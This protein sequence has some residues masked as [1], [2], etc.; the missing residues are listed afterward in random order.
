MVVG[1]GGIFISTLF[2]YPFPYVGLTITV[3]V[4]SVLNLATTK[5]Q[6]YLP[7]DFKTN[8]ELCRKATVC[9]VYGFFFAGSYYT[10][11]IFNIIFA[12]LHDYVV[13][14]VI[15]TFIYPFLCAGIRMVAE[16]LTMLMCPD[17]MLETQFVFELWPAIYHQFQFATSPNTLVN[18]SLLIS[19]FLEQTVE[20]IKFTRSWRRLRKTVRKKLLSDLFNKNEQKDETCGQDASIS[21]SEVRSGIKHAALERIRTTATL[22]DSVD[23]AVHPDSSSNILPPRTDTIITKA[24]KAVVQVSFEKSIKTENA[25]QGDP[26]GPEAGG[27]PLPL[28]KTKDGFI[29]RDTL[30][31]IALSNASKEEHKKEECCMDTAGQQDKEKDNRLN[32]SLH[33]SHT[34][35]NDSAY[36]QVHD[37]FKGQMK[38]VSFYLECY[39]WHYCNSLSI[40]NFSTLVAPSIYF[41]LYTIMYWLP[42]NNHNYDIVRNGYITQEKILQSYQYVAAHIVLKLCT[43]VFLRW[44]LKYK[45]EIDNKAGM[46]YLLQKRKVFLLVSTTLIYTTCLYAQFIPTGIDVKFKFDWISRKVTLSP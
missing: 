26:L 10:Y 6:W 31:S 43:L 7:A 29:S 18:I 40:A 11:V 1:A 37:R 12:M 5:S 34:D 23:S 41:V 14:E 20:M 3:P 30:L 24:D 46:Y 27:I 17:A 36:Y 16:Y 35:S 2:L 22:E 4:W 28:D 33:P 21:I 42:Y 19:A 9:F 45:Y 15:L 44:Y 32:S 38:K 25:V 13:A 8:P 39:N